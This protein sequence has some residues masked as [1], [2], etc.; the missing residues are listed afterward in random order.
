M[1]VYGF[2]IG[3][4]GQLIC[5]IMCFK[6]RYYLDGKVYFYFTF[7]WTITA[8]YDLFPIFGWM[9]P[10]S[11][12]EYGY[13]NLMGCLFTLIFFLQN[14]NAPSPVT[15]I[16]FATN[17]I[18]FVLLTIGSFAHSTGVVKAGGIFCMITA[19]LAYYSSFGMTINE[20]FQKVYIPLFDGK[21]FGQKLH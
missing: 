10:L 20:R 21:D 1:T 17:F 12:R 15:R 3:S 4:L 5:G 14:L 13:H 7:N 2:L 11:D 16:S 18:G 6:E 9:E 8:C 19:S